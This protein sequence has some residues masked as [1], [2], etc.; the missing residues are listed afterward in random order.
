MSELWVDEP[1]PGLA[2]A[3]PKAGHRYTSDAFWLAGFALECWRES[4]RVGPARVLDLGT[5]SGI[6]GALLAGQGMHVIGIDARNEWQPYWQR[7]LSESRWPGSLAL[8]HGDV[9]QP[10]EGTFDLVVANP[11]YF[12]A[13]AGPTSPDP[14]RAA[15]RTESSA[16]LAV[17]WDAV[18]AVMDPR[19]LACFVLP[20]ERVDEAL[21]LGLRRTRCFSVGAKR[22]VM[23][24]EHG[25]GPPAPVD[26]ASDDQTAGWYAWVGASNALEPWP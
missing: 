4:G 8:R 12:P 20:R 16:T 21:P 15:A 24:V 11:P 14:W 6:V 22:A 25:M 19:G 1:A 3:Q 18:Q 10:P 23:R 5:G 2:I 26:V 7:T 13:G 9:R 17:W